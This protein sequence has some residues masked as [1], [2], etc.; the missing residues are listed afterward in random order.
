M[1][2]VA[3]L[4]FTASHKR[5]AGLFLVGSSVA[6]VYWTTSRHPPYANIATTVQEFNFCGGSVDAVE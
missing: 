4:Y 1:D 2:H 6:G 5:V 3:Q